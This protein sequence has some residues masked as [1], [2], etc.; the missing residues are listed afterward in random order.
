M[1][2][3]GSTPSVRSCT[4]TYYDSGGPMGMTSDSESSSMT[5]CDPGGGSITLSF[6]TFSLESCC[7][8]LTLYDGDEAGPVFGTYTGATSPGVVTSTSDCITA[9]FTADSSVTTEGWAA[10]IS[11]G[12][13][14][15]LGEN[16]S[17]CSIA[18]MCASGNCVEGICCESSCDDGLLCNGAETC[19][20]G[21]CFSGDPVDCDDF[22]SCTADSCFEGIGCQSEPIPGCAGFDAGPRP[23]A[24]SPRDAGPRIDAGRPPPGPG[25]RGG[26]RG[27]CAVAGE[28]HGD[29]AG[30]FVTGLAISLALARRRRQRA[31]R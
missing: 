13:P 17:A 5:F 14:P 31:K 2:L 21:T 29:V 27:C 28:T 26:R 10:T 12:E 9:R 16:G 7:D 3:H 24:G 20:T 8:F 23:D 19:G 30:L 4:G 25:G 1:Y 6:S 11:C 22:D 15:M 18:S